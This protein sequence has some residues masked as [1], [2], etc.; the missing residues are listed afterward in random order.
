[1]KINF[2]LVVFC[3]L[4]TGCVYDFSSNE[5]VVGGLALIDFTDRSGEEYCEKMKA[6]F[7]E[8]FSA[9]EQ[10]RIASIYQDRA[11]LLLLN[12]YLENATPENTAKV[13]RLLKEKWGEDIYNRVNTGVFHGKSCQLK[14]SF[15]AK[16]EEKELRAK[17]DD[18]TVHSILVAI[19]AVSLRKK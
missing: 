6:L 7:S 11:F 8:H 9:E 3:I 14:R 19:D 16:E 2:G 17:L 18:P 5:S 4:L 10:T 15:M 1:M 13:D 12:E